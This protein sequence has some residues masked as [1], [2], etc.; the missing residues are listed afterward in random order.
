MT[1]GEISDEARA[2]IGS[3]FPMVSRS[4][5]R[6]PRD[7]GSLISRT[8]RWFQ[9]GQDEPCPMKIVIAIGGGDSENASSGWILASR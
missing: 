1:R 3:L 8:R 6:P 9:G 2:V 5:T 7:I 4:L